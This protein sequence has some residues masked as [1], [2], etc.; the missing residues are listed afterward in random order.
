MFLKISQIFTNF[1]RKTSLPEPL[2]NFFKNETLAQ[3]FSF[4]IYEMFKN[5]FISRTPY[6]A[7]SVGVEF[8]IFLFFFGGGGG[9][10]AK[11]CL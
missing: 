7:A 5:T 1:T 2:F 3:M 8:F 4:K 9:G 10:E 6:V 11:E